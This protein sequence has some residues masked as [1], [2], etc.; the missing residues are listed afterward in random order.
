MDYKCFTKDEEA[1]IISLNDYLKQ[2][3]GWKLGHVDD[4]NCL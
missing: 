1:S 4:F 3:T 2:E